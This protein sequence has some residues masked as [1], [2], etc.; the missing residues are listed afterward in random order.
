MGVILALI[1]LFIWNMYKE[2]EE[3]W[4]EVHYRAMVCLL[5]TIPCSFLSLADA[6]T[7]HSICFL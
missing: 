7:S 1:Q 6:L 3:H 5:Q 4:E 2:V